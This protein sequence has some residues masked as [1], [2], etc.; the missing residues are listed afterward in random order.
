IVQK[1]S[2]ELATKRVESTDLMLQAGRATTR[3]LLEAQESFLDAKNSLSSAIVNYL[4]SYLELL[5]DTEQLQLDDTG[6]W[7]GDLYEKII[8]EDTK[9]S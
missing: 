5:R 2:L 1:N 7:K 6:V 3:D 9:N 4:I 8:G